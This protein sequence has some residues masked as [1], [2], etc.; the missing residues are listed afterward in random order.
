M[1][2]EPMKI[3]VVGCGSIGK[4]HLDVLSRRSG[5]EVAACDMTPEA[6]EAVAAISSNITFFGNQQEAFAWSPSLT[7]VAVPNQFHRPVAEAAF[8]ARSHVLCE[9][10]IADTV[11]NGKAIVAAAEAAG[12]RLMVGYTERYRPAFLFIEDMVK[13]GELGTLVGG[14]AMVGTYNTIVCSQASANDPMFGSIIVNYTHELDLLGSIFGSAKDV[15]ARSNQL[16]SKTGIATRPSL[17]AMLIEYETGALVSVHMDYIQHPQ[18]RLLEIY[19]DRR[20]LEYDLQTNTVRI[21]DTDADGHQTRHFPASRNEIFALEH[22]DAI[23]MAR[24]NDA[25]RVTGR[26]ALAVLEVAEL[27]INRLSETGG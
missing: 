25:P 22:D 4:R 1:T 6:A 26:Q 10:P 23:N 27:A 21:F 7:V 17:A 15:D 16:G 5:I 9:K 14:R 12:C 11:A 20:T 13:K 3:L 24:N 8:E 2:S 18:R 19:G